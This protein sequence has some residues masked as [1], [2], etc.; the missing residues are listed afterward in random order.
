MK[1]RTEDAPEHFRLLVAGQE[2]RDFSRLTDLLTETGN[3]HL[4]LDCVPS[5]REVLARLGEASYD[6]LLCDGDPK[7]E[8]MLEGW[9][10][11]QP[12]MPIVFLS[13]KGSDAAAQ[14]AIQAAVCRGHERCHRIQPCIALS[15]LGAIETYCKER[16]RQSSDV[17]LS[18]MRRTVELSR[19]LVMITDQS[20]VLEYVNPAFEQ[21]TGYAQTEV[22][23]QTLGI[24]KSDQQTG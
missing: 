24:L 13:G 6:L 22:I 5:T 20:G 21:L 1:E 18:K 2:E 10:R 11:L 23:G 3:G 7:D 17:L 15:I 19:D 8:T 12:G 9:R 4:R 14:V 16:Q